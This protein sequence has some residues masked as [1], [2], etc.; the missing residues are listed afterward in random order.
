MTARLLLL[1]TLLTQFMLAGSLAAPINPPITYSDV[2]MRDNLS[3]VGN[4]PHTL[5]TIWDSPDIVVCNTPTP[6][7]VS[8]NPIAGGTSYLFV[9]LRNDRVRKEQPPQQI[10]GNLHLYRT[11]PGGNAQWSGDWTPINIVFNILLNPGEVR[12]IQMPW[13]DVPGPGHF[14]LLARWVSAGDPMT[15]PETADTQQNTRNNNNIAWKNVN[16]VSLTPGSVE[17]R[18]FRI[19]NVTKQEQSNDLVVT[20]PH[21]ESFL[22]HGTLL[23]DL[24]PELFERWLAA[25]APGEGIK[26]AE[27]TQVQ[28]FEPTSRILDL[29]LPPQ[30]SATLTLRFIAND[31]PKEGSYLLDVIQFARPDNQEEKIDSGGVRYTV[32]IAP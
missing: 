27:G 15:F 12:T 31:S 26:P 32:Q 13:F 4:E 11:T 5:G 2:W 30:G 10:K 28:I 8:E 7:A 6:C 17:E 16:S 19:S 20:V 21:G 9:T 18:P 14:C 24:G 25:G 29:M 3:D 23:I 22:E 1:V